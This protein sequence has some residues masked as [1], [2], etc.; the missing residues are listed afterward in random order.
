MQISVVST[1][2]GVPINQGQQASNVPGHRNRPICHKQ[3]RSHSDTAPFQGDKRPVPGRRDLAP[4]GVVIVA[5]VW[6]MQMHV[7]GCT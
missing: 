2:I 6:S 1:R 7:V 5:G 4:I 3:S